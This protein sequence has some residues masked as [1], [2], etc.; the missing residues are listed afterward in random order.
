MCLTINF[1]HLCYFI[2]KY[3]EINIKFKIK[4]WNLD[5]YTKIEY[6]S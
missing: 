6:L 1:N 2:D 3:I 4:K 5:T